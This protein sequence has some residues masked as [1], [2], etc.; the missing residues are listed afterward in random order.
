MDD[1]TSERATGALPPQPEAVEKASEAKGQLPLER[2]RLR[3]ERQK[4][5]LEVRLKRRELAEK[6]RSSIWKDFLGNP[7][8]IAIVGGFLT[9]LTTILTNFYNSRE[10]REAEAARAEI[11]RENARET[12]E[13][14]LIK[15][16]VDSP[17]RDTVRENLRFLVDAGLLP[18]Y[19]TSITHYLAANPDAAPR[20]GS[21]VAFSPSGEVISEAL[22]KR[23][24]DKVTQF[25]AFLQEKGFSSLGNNVSVFVY[26]KERPPPG[27]YGM[28]GEIPNSFTD[29]EKNI[30]FIHL[31]LTQ[32]DAVA[33]REYAH[34][35]LASAIAPELSLQT[36]VESA[37]ADYLPAT[38]LNS[39]AFGSGLKTDIGLQ[40]EFFRNIDKS[41]SYYTVSKDWFHRGVVWAEALWACRQRTS[42]GVDDL[43]LSA[44]QHAMVKPEQ[45]P[46]IAQRFGTALAAAA[47]PYGQCLGEEIA[48]RQLPRNSS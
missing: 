45:A 21:S 29:P 7:L 19:G 8:T 40:P 36:E 5:A 18:T 38:F 23:I 35:A 43:V 42:R 28:S 44:W 25:K 39:P 34:Y 14:D 22:Q 46:L 37:L 10:N 9:L 32:D 41:E 27:R 33:L 3:L 11:T 15:R 47:P 24:K 17:S 1:H 13:A 12:L 20:L 31:D 26:S 30:L 6:K 48:R 16:F 4:H 2:E